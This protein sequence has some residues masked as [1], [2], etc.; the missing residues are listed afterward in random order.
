MESLILNIIKIYHDE[1][2]HCGVEKTIQG[3]GNNYW[4]H[5]MRRKVQ[6]YIDNCITC[7]MA[8]STANSREGDVQITETPSTPFEIIYI[9][10]FSPIKE[11]TNNFKHILVVI[12]AFSRFTWLFP[13]KST[14]SSEVIKHLSFLF[15]N[16][17]CPI[18]LI[19]DR[20]TA[21]PSQEFANFINSYKIKHHL[22]AVAAPW[23]NGLVERANRFIISS[24]KKVVSSQVNWSNHI[25]MIQYVINNSYHSSI[26]TS[27][28]KMLFGIHQR[29][30]IDA[31]LVKCLNDIAK[32][33]LNKDRNTNWDIAQES[34]RKIKE[35]N[36]SYYDVKHKK[37][38]YKEGDYVFIKDSAIKQGEDKK[39]K[40]KYKGPYRVAKVL[41]KNRYV[42]KDIPGFNVT[43]KP[44]D[45]ILSSDRMK[46][47]TKP[48]DHVS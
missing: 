11:S 8:N 46:P 3:I 30:H 44:Y 36:K 16:L 40:A 25:V 20:G 1:M 9:D 43:A 13:V 6:A 7:L 39:L 19:S 41:N 12:E 48:V 32:V 33:D 31:E 17:I 5:T 24:L 47:W 26:K 22:V 28:A 42:R 23:A 15:K 21:F 18:T 45:S 27:P 34:T 10:H 35:Y 4:F 2:A 14:T 38:R 37:P 29:L